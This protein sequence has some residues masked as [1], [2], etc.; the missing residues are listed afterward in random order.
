M[1]LVE[2]VVAD[3]AAIDH[4]H[5]SGHSLVTPV[6][7][8]AVFEEAFASHLDRHP[9]GGGAIGA[10]LYLALDGD[11]EGVGGFLVWKML[12]LPIPMVV[13]VVHEPCGFCFTG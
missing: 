3:M 2:N 10:A 11:A 9:V 6:P 8:L 13:G 5:F 1:F 7:A 12:A 4:Q